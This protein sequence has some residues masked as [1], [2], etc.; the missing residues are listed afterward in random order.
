MSVC[1]L[2]Q[3]MEWLDDNRSYLKHY[4][5]TLPWRTDQTMKHVRQMF[6]VQRSDLISAPAECKSETLPLEPP[7][8]GRII[9]QWIVEKYDEKAWTGFL[10]L[11]TGSAG[12]FNTQLVQCDSRSVLRNR[13]RL[14][15][16]QEIRGDLVQYPERERESTTQL[17]QNKRDGWIV[18]IPCR[19][20]RGFFSSPVFCLQIN[21]KQKDGKHVVPWNVLTVVR[22]RRKLRRLTSSCACVCVLT[23]FALDTTHLLRGH[24]SLQ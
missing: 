21:R 10:W 18:F 2:W 1:R 16:G 12:G 17:I 15:R 4:L 3:S 22:Q 6:G 13:R 5:R 23:F 11:K 9:L 24:N 8:A 7:G 19:P 20:A 14:Q